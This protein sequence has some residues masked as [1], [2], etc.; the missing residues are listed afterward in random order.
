MNLS[1]MH[2]KRCAECKKRIWPWQM[3]IR[4]TI[5]DYIHYECWVSKK[6]EEKDGKRT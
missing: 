3:N 5:C 6:K 4:I 2:V 1:E